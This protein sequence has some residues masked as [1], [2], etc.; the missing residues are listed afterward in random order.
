MLA[1]EK[2]KTAAIAKPSA[3]GKRVDIKA[4]YKDAIKKYPRTMAYLA[5]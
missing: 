5:K 4:V 3:D 2:P 1:L